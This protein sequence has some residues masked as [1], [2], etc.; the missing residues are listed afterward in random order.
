MS[1]P[2]SRLVMSASNQGMMVCIYLP[3]HLGEEVEE[4]QPERTG[5]PTQG[6]GLMGDR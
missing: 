6:A 1:L 2:A 3:R 4:V 5:T